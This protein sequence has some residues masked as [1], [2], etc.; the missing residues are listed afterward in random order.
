MEAASLDAARAVDAL[1]LEGGDLAHRARV[2]AEASRRSASW[3]HAAAKTVEASAGELGAASRALDDAISDVTRACEGK[4]APAECARVHERLRT[5]HMADVA[6]PDTMEAA[7]AGFEGVASPALATKV[8]RVAKA[9]RSLAAKTSLVLKQLDETKIKS[10]REALARATK[11]IE[12]ACGE[13]P[14]LPS[15]GPAYAAEWIAPEKAD[16]RKLTV[17]VKVKPPGPLRATFATF[18]KSDDE[19]SPLY[20]A[21][22]DGGF[23][24]GLVLVKRAGNTRRAYVV[25]NRHVVA[26]SDEADIYLDGG[27]HLGSAPVIYADPWYDLAVLALP[28]NAPFDHGFAFAPTPAKDQLPVIATGFPGIGARPSYQTTR[29][30]VSN[31][32][33]IFED[34]GRKTLYVQH[35]AP[36]DGGSS[37]GPLTTEAGRLLG[38]NT[39]KLRGRENVG[40]AA[41]A[42]A[43][44]EVAHHA[45]E[46]ERLA[47]NI[48]WRRQRARDACLALV[49]ELVAQKPRLRVAEQ[50]IS[51]WMTAR[52]G[53]ESFKDLAASNADLAA[54]WKSD[55]IEA[56]RMAVVLRIWRDARAE[57]GVDANEACDRPNEES[58]VHLATSDRVG[59]KVRIGHVEHA[60]AMR[61]ERGLW[62]L[63]SIDVRL[64]QDQKPDAPKATARDARSRGR[65]A[66]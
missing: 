55:P 15:V 37:G 47:S 62:R 63:V 25:T 33:F 26:L 56:M 27:T 11:G 44:A 58:W 29:G 38:V 10:V 1:K 17:I 31:E 6:R 7:A 65:R 41:P 60:I 51:S 8:E 2:Y 52:E 53:L 3:V 57:G 32:R 34:E 28:E 54:I 59:F 18:A 40:L 21:V 36:I 4:K 9:A 49:G 48:D 22:A 35:T 42:F 13:L 64:A 19:L 5:L 43:V 66:P 61:W 14:I 24:S 50:M 39:M 23:G 20:R 45:T 12:G 30:Y 16:V 46:L